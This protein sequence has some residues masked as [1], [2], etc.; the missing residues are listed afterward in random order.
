MSATKIYCDGS[1]LGNPGKGGWAVLVCHDGEDFSWSGGNPATTNN[2]MELVAA[3]QAMES[4]QG[5]E[6]EIEV[7]TDSQYVIKGI[8]EWIIGWKAKNFKGVKNVELWKNLDTLVTGLN[9]KWIWVKGHAGHPQN[10]FV[11]KL[12]KK[13]A[14]AS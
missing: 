10:E 13:A 9:V 7:Y 2:Q 3:I 6:G 12:A 5:H 1:C 8:T 4:V 11:D 14:E